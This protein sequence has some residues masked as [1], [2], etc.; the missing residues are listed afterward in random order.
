M[1]YAVSSLAPPCLVRMRCATTMTER[2]KTSAEKM[3]VPQ[4]TKGHLGAGT[5]GG[6]QEAVSVLFYAMTG[7]YDD[8]GASQGERDPGSQP[9]V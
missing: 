2:L 9:G 6:A 4:T 5:D 8:A 7:V 1:R 3:P